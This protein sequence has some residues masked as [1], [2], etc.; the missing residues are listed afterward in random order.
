MKHLI[1]MLN[2]V[3]IV[4]ELIRSSSFVR[5]IVIWGGIIAGVSIVGIDQIIN[6]LGLQN[7]VAN[8]SQFL[9]QNI[10]INGIVNQL[11]QLFKK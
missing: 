10:D 1:I 8:L 3:D 2:P 11:K 4:V 6:T 5:T 9:H 7:M